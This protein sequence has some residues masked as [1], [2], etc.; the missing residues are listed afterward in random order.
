MKKYIL[1]YLLALVGAIF[2]IN[3]FFKS[4]KSDPEIK[5]NYM[6]KRVFFEEKESDDKQKQD[7]LNEEKV[8]EIT[9]Q[10]I[11]DNPEL[12]IKSMNDFVEKKNEA[13][14][15]DLSQNVLAHSE[16][17]YN[18][19]VDPRVNGANADF[20]IVEFFDYNCGYCEAMFEVKMKILETRKNIGF[21]LKEAPVLGENSNLISRYAI[22][23]NMTDQNKY[24]DFQRAI[25]SSKDR[26]EESALLSIVSSLGLNMQKFNESLE[27]PLITKQIAANLD[28]A[29]KIGING[30]PAYIIG[31]E[32]LVG[33]TEYDKIINILNKKVSN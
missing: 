25:M 10:V 6:S 17:L 31:D 9:K 5:N 28:L 16:D 2:F 33:Y 32:L 22:A 23:V 24:I 20:F 11:I 3:E 29:S 18:N 19:S 27:S 26:L 15:K 4:Y 13:R 7:P 8:K 1:L 30:T 14:K 12:M 21:I